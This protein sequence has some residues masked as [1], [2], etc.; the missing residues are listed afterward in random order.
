MSKV[1]VFGG[2]GFLG[3]HVCD[4]LTLIGHEVT[5]FDIKKSEYLDS[6]QKMIIGDILD[7]DLV[8]ESVKDM[9]YVYHFAAMADIA[10]SR[11]KPKEAVK[12]NI[13]GTMN[14]LDACRL[15]KVKR[16]VFSSSVYVYSDQGSFYRTTK[17][18]CELLIEN[19]FEEFKLE[20]TI[21]RYGSLYGTRANEFNFI[22]NTIKQALTSGKIYRKGDGTE[23]RDYINVVDAAK[24]SVDILNNDFINSYVM[25]T[26]DQSRMVKNLL[27]TIRE[28]FDNQINIQYL[29]ENYKGHYQLTP[30][31]FK[32]KV[33][34]K[35]TPKTYHDLGQGILECIYYEYQKLVEKGIETRFNK[36]DK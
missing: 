34:I 10:D 9:D 15:H 3:S 35:L 19:Y 24:S 27:D 36:F 20:F 23:M 18:S 11:D 4:Q 28:I 17:Q 5:I 16:F 12:F 26:G 2:S 6:N 14:I 25:I 8:V 32:P 21:L 1:L 30:Y 13:L 33:A 31:S 7:F 29:T 22:S